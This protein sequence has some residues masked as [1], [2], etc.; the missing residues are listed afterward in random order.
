MTGLVLADIAEVMIWFTA[1]VMLCSVLVPLMLSVRKI[2][3][4][5]H[6]R[7]G[8]S[9]AD[10]RLQLLSAPLEDKELSVFLASLETLQAW[11]A[12]H[13]D[14]LHDLLE[15]EQVHW[16]AAESY[17]VWEKIDL[18]APEL[19]TLWHKLCLARD[20]SEQGGLD[21]ALDK[22]RAHPPRNAEERAWLQALPRYPQAN[23]RCFES[24]RVALLAG[25]VSLQPAHGS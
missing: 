2:R 9:R 13:A 25:L 8:M 14:A 17:E 20:L 22:A 10:L 23:L 18:D 21:A 4:T 11:G 12:Q 3:G 6:L 7:E 24:Q 19:V 15:G 16:H 5:E 1:S